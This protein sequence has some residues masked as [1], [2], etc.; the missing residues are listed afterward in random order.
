MR[1]NHNLYLIFMSEDFGRAASAIAAAYR[2][3]P[4]VV[5]LSSELPEMSCYEA[6]VQLMAVGPRPRVILV[7]PQ[8]SDA[9]VFSRWMCG[10]AGCV[11]QD[12]PEEDLVRTV[13]ANGSGQ[14]F[15]PRRLLSHQPIAVEDQ[16]AE[17]GRV[18]D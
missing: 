2:L 14:S 10:G 4:R 13:R 9:D 11:M 6:C 16:N 8:I 12:D 17:S 1:P 15:Q 7:F 5:V 3:Q 18:A